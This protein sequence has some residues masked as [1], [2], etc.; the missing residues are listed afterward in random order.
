VFGDDDT[1]AGS[2]AG[3]RI[4]GGVARDRAALPEAPEAAV[5]WAHSSHARYAIELVGIG[6]AYFVFAKVDLALASITPSATPIWPPTGLALAA[7]MLCGYRVWPAIFAAA[8]LANATTAGS[9]YTSSAIALGN[10][11]ESLREDDARRPPRRALRAQ[12]QEALDHRRRSLAPA[13]DSICVSAHRSWSTTS[14]TSRM[15]GCARGS[16][17]S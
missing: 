5:R 11:F 3:D 2:T 1:L 12:R 9:L 17:I 7:V 6:V 8:W 10:T 16:R 15:R 14:V 13:P 4:A